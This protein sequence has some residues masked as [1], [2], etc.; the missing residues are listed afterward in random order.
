MDSHTQSSDDISPFLEGRFCYA[1]TLSWLKTV[2]THPCSTWRHFVIALFSFFV[3]T[4]SKEEGRVIESNVAFLHLVKS[5]SHW[6]LVLYTNQNRPVNVFFEG[7]TYQNHFLGACLTRWN[8]FWIH[9]NASLLFTFGDAYKKGAE[10]LSNRRWKTHV[11]WCISE[12]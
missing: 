12:K 6:S 7:F 4:Q 9:Q 10:V 3:V 2:P 5:A 1:R 8:G 11:H